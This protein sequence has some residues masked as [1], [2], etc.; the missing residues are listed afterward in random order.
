MDEFERSQRIRLPARQSNRNGSARADA[1]E[2]AISDARIIQN[3]ADLTIHRKMNGQNHSEKNRKGIQGQFH[4]LAPLLRNTHFPL[5][6]FRKM[7]PAYQHQVNTLCPT[8][9][10]PR[11]RVPGEDFY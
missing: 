11:Q 6:L 5:Q 10:P 2:E 3:A 8:S 7:L 4:W 1:P 9:N